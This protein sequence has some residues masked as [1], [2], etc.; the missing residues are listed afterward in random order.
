[1]LSY[2]VDV[3]D[4]MDAFRG[5]RNQRLAMD[6]ATILS[7]TD[8]DGNIT[9]VNDRFCDLCGFAREELIGKTYDVLNSQV[10]QSDFFEHM[11]GEI[12]QAKP[13]AG[14]VCNKNKKNQLF[15]VNMTIIPS[16]T[17]AGN[18]FEFQAIGFEI[19][20]AKHDQE[21]AIEQTAIADKANEAKSHFLAN[22]SHELRTPMNGLMG[23]AT[24]LKNTSLKDQQIKFVDGI[25]SS[26]DHQLSI[27][28]NILDLSKMQSGHMEL[29]KISFDL[30]DIGVCY[31][32]PCSI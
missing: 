32:D 24:L 8:L 7:S 17:E 22:M 18:V 12:T 14:E 26:A 5:L 1:M 13:W 19:T 27:L 30:L 29:E 6:Q 3:N 10:H 25:L 16:L 20:E 21:K 15:W 11:W 23:M 31:S 28:N 9:Y 2:L 4:K